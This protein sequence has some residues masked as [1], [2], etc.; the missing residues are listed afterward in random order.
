ML[1]CVVLAIVVTGVTSEVVT[2]TG[3]TTVLFM[4]YVVND[5]ALGWPPVLSEFLRESELVVVKPMVVIAS[6]LISGAF[7]S[8]LACNCAAILSRFDTFL[9]VGARCAGIVP[10]GGWDD[11]MD[12]F[13]EP[14][15]E[16][17]SNFVTLATEDVPIWRLETLF[18]GRVRTSSVVDL[19]LQKR[20][21]KYGF[22]LLGFE[23]N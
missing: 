9:I 13:V 3:D 21:A 18:G 7:G 22:K 2:S 20:K 14:F 11:G 16:L 19:K 5:L 1:S 17:T 8:L 4:V 12:D 15:S 6:V 10:G 23:T